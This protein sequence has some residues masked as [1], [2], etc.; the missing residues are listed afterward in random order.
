MPEK[1]TDI[2]PLQHIKA[3]VYG[4]FGCGKTTFATTFPKP[5]LFFDF[6]NGYHTYRG[7]PDVD[8]TLYNDDPSARRPSAYK[9]F[10]KDLLREAK[11]PQYATYVLDSTTFLLEALIREII[12]ANASSQAHEGITLQEW[13]LVTNRFTRLFLDIRAFSANF[14][15]I[16][17][18]NTIQDEIT[19]EIKRFTV[20]IGKKFAQ[21]AP[22][23]FDEVYRVFSD[24]GD[25]KIQTQ[26]CRRYAARTRITAYDQK[27]RG[28]RPILDQ[29]EP[30]DF[31]KIAEK[32]QK[33]T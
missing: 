31:Q 11:D 27:A 9:D 6:D 1:A 22:G 16:G 25:F 29:Y 20:M 4:E 18:E 24:K 28:P 14:V 26:P 3:L 17:H 5:L 2:K 23:Y 30:A 8:Y 12:S 21:K 33:L 7:V 32:V 10:K 13:Q 15:V 19:S